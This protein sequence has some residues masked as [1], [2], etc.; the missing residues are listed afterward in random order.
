MTA[1]QN[2]QQLSAHLLVDCSTQTMLEHSWLIEDMLDYLANR[3]GQ[4]QVTGSR[5]NLNVI[6]MGAAT[7]QKIEPSSPGRFQLPGRSYDCDLGRALRVL[8]DSLDTPGMRREGPVEI[9][10][11]LASEP[12][13]D[14]EG[15][16]RALAHRASITVFAL[17]LPDVIRDETLRRIRTQNRSYRLGSTSLGVI[18]NAFLQVFDILRNSVT[19]LFGE[20]TGGTVS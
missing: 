7:C 9:F 6:I 4:D 19:R 20:E 1:N 3:L 16:I 12:S 18:A 8:T 17:A 2:G 10:V 5:V 13:G 15:R 11:L 14:W